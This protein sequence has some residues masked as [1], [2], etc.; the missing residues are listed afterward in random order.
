MTVAMYRELLDRAEAKMKQ[1]RSP[2]ESA[3]AL[4]P[5]TDCID[6]MTWAE[7]IALRQ[8]LES[9]GETRILRNLAYDYDKQAWIA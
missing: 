7:R 5:L 9:Q 1:A 2:R 3:E 4:H 8:A 6:S